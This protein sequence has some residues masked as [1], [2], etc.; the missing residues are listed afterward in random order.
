MAIKVLSSY[1]QLSTDREHISRL[2]GECCIR[3]VLSGWPSCRINAFC[4]GFLSRKLQ[5]RQSDTIL[6]VIQN[7]SAFFPAAE[8]QTASK[9]LISRS[10]RRICGALTHQVTSIANFAFE[11]YP[12][13]LCFNPNWIN[14][15]LFQASPL[16]GISSALL[17]YLG[18]LH[19]RRKY[20]TPAIS[21]GVGNPP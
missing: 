4:H 12:P 6:D 2:F 18:P 15:H 1:S 14:M 19:P 3:L 20:S 7:I 21:T 10:N 5:N 16:H 13:P 8:I 17:K 11:C 9:Y